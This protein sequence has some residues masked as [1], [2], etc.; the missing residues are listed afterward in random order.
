MARFGNALLAALLAPTLLGGTARA[1][2]ALYYIDAA[3]SICSSEEISVTV[4][5]PASS[6]SKSIIHVPVFFRTASGAV[7]VTYELKDRANQAIVPLTSIVL[8][9]QTGR[10]VQASETSSLEIGPTES[11]AEDGLCEGVFLADGRSPVELPDTWSDARDAFHGICEQGGLASACDAEETAIF[12]GHPAGEQAFQPSTDFCMDL[13]RY[14]VSVSGDSALVMARR[15]KSGGGSYSSSS[16]GSKA[17]GGW[18]SASR[19]SMSPYG[20]TESRMGSVY[21]RGYSSTSYGYSG[22]GGMSPRLTAT[23]VAVVGVG[24]FTGFGAWRW[25]QRGTGSQSSGE[26]NEGSRCGW[27]LNGEE[28]IR[29]DIMTHGFIPS[30]MSYPLQLTVKQLQITGLNASAMCDPNAWSNASEVAGVD[31]F[32][33]VAA[34]EELDEDLDP[35]LGFIALPFFL[36]GLVCFCWVCNPQAKKYRRIKK[37]R[38]MREQAD[39]C[40]VTGWWPSALNLA[41]TRCTGGSNG[42]TVTSRID[43]NIQTGGRISGFMDGFAI[44]GCV[45]AASPSILMISWTRVDHPMFES[46]CRLQPDSGRMLFTGSWVEATQP[47]GCLPMC[48]ARSGTLDLSCDMRA[49]VPSVANVVIGSPVPEQ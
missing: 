17:V 39:A 7:A 2:E 24:T 49:S 21:P 3:R 18:D 33:S 8:S 41:G 38:S 12:A 44:S 26:C 47:N 40:E 14:Y 27:D 22:R 32:F 42:G 45:T 9:E 43:I 37:W 19:T 48:S 6:A 36:I 10:R 16:S 4:E 15:L 20:Y 5:I 1:Q 35:L 46:I 34:V 13:A 25:S 28:L 30:E 11:A 23:T 29:D 31:V